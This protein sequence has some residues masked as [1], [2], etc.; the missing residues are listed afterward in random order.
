MLFQFQELRIQ[1]ALPGNLARQQQ[2]PLVLKMRQPAKKQRS[3][4]T[5]K[6]NVV[7]Q[8]I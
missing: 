2:V 1:C 3:E 6:K 7:K 4:N 8:Q 5:Y